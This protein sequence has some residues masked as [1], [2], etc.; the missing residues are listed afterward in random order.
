MKNI[1]DA[2]VDFF[3]NAPIIIIVI[4]LALDSIRNI[5]ASF[6]N[7]NPNSFFGKILYGKRDKNIVK[8]ALVELGYFE[9]KGS[10]IVTRMKDIAKEA[11]ISSS[12]IKKD[13]ADL[14][15]IILLSKYVEKF[16]S[17][18][19]YGGNNPTQSEYYIDTMEIAHN[20]E[21]KNKMCAIM[22][23]L[24]QKDY[25]NRNCPQIIFTPKGGN[26]LFA[27]SVA[28]KFNSHLMVSKSVADKSRVIC[29]ED[30]LKSFYIN[31]EGSWNI[32]NL[33]K[34][35]SSI[36]VDC[37]TSGGS[38]LLNIVKDVRS[39]PDLKVNSPSQVYVLFK[40]DINEEIDVDALFK[41][42][43][44]KLIRFFD[45]D[46]RAKEMMY[47]LKCRGEEKKTY[48]SAFNSEDRNKAKE[49]IEYLKRINKHYYKA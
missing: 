9:S 49:I 48:P 23:W 37:N 42:C 8:S 40:V 32:K 30:P 10:E 12:T 33:K 34:K 20:E 7:V 15:L 24:I 11:N 45:L 28:Q 44:C 14:Q 1:Y 5:L 19:V 46:E 17:P 47:E 18:M 31:Y 6:V 21:D 2:I 41:S 39:I 36:V 25:K 26:P 43:D 13:E 4:V 22:Y 38:Q 35:S 16:D 27:L 3:S 29:T